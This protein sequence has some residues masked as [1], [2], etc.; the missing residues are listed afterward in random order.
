MNCMATS[1]FNN[2][3]MRALLHGGTMGVTE[4]DV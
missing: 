4:T 3:P 1:H 2:D